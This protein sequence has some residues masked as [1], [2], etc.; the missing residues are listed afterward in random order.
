MAPFTEKN[1]CN[2]MYTPLRL[3]WNLKIRWFSFSRSV[4][5]GSMLIFWGVNW[6]VT[7][8]SN[9]L[10]WGLNTLR[11]DPSCPNGSSVGPSDDISSQDLEVRKFNKWTLEVTHSSN[12]SGK[13]YGK[14]M[15]CLLHVSVQ[16]CFL[17]QLNSL[18]WE[19]LGIKCGSQPESMQEKQSSCGT[20]AEAPSAMEVG[21]NTVICIDHH[22]LLVGLGCQN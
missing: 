7:I 17:L 5:S 12:N 14:N 21:D 10:L 11:S 15:P 8:S 20:E 6:R 22:T 9:I 19:N 13:N 4:F 16:T 1:M 2:L 3:T 18:L